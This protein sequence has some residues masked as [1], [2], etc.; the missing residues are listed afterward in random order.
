MKKALSVYR[1][2]NKK[3]STPDLV[4]HLRAQIKEKPLFNKEG[5]FKI[6]YAVQTSVKPPSFQIFVNHKEL[7][8]DSYMRFLQKSIREKFNF[9]GI[10][11]K[12]EAKNRE[13]KEK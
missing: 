5:N 7:L 9:D 12:L 2:F 4:E 11:F 8:N 10:P 13:R 6:F 3:V 1:N